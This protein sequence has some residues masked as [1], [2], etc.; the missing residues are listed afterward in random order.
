M[1]A[2]AEADVAVVSAAVG[3]F[4]E[5]V[6]KGQIASALSWVGMGGRMEAGQE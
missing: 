3:R 4:V 1:V 5:V 6:R 2:V